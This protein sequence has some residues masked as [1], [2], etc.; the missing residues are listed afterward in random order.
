MTQL[1]PSIIV[2][3]LYYSA[4]SMAIA[5]IVGAQVLHESPFS[6]ASFQ[7]AVPLGFLLGAVATYFNRTA[8]FAIAA[9]NPKALR[10]TLDAWLIDR[11]YE[12]DSNFKAE[13]D[14]QSYRR[15][16]WQRWTTGRIFVKWQGKSVTLVGRSSLVRPLQQELYAE[17]Q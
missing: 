7:S 5:A 2:V 6:G 15:S 4:G 10:K 17:A 13:G 14:F 3:F 8:E 11:G 16:S 9:S 12:L 1:G